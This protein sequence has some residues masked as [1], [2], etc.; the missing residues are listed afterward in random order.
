MT[1]H[2]QQKISS[3]LDEGNIQGEIWVTALDDKITSIRL[4]NI[5]KNWSSNIQKML[6]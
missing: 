4:L 3:K 1:I 6:I 5:K 2:E